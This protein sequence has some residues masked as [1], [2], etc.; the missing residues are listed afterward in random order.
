M[1]MPMINY[2]EICEVAQPVKPVIK[3]KYIDLTTLQQASLGSDT[4]VKEMLVM[5]AKE[6]PE[7]IAESENLLK[8]REMELFS[9]VIHKLK[10]S[11]LTLGVEVLRND[12]IFME[13]KS[14]KG[15]QLDDVKNKFYQ[16]LELWSKTKKE[17]ELVI[18]Q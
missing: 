9:K 18:L 8:M 13:E 11:L 6:I 14:R 17:L 1:K 3:H 10:S 4:F 16:M 5:L 7:M 12:L 2:G 15:L